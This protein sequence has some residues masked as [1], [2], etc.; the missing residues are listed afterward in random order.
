MIKI[1]FNL[2]LITNFKYF[3]LCFLFLKSII[4]ITVSLI[5]F[6]MLYYNDGIVKYHKFYMQGC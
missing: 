3:H 5:T 2:T 4:I 1:L 6:E